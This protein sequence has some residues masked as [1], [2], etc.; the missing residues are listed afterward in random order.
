MVGGLGGRRVL[1]GWIVAGMGLPVL[2]AVLV[3]VD[4]D[5]AL[6]T[7]LYLSLAVLVAIVGGRWPGLAA[8]VAAALLLNFF[9]VPP[10]H[11]F[12]VAAR[13][14]VVA[15][16]VFTLTAAAVA[17]VVDA[18]ARRREEARA[19]GREA[20]TLA[21]LNRQVL[22]GSYDVTPPPEPAPYNFR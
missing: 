4:A 2:T 22:G 9:V 17:A 3:G 5:I 16:V 15:L 12:D 13:S 20:A 10:L 11:T 19:A 1:I 8:A 7:M 14:D 18:A 21:M 6:A